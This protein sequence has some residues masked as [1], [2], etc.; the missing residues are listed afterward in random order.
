[1]KK[2]V[3]L[4][5]LLTFGLAAFTQGL[6]NLT[7]SLTGSSVTS[8]AANAAKQLQTLMPLSNSSNAAANSMSQLQLLGL[9]PA[10]IQKFI[11]A[12]ADASTAPQEQSNPLQDVLQTVFDMKIRQDSMQA[13]LD[14]NSNNNKP[15]NDVKPNEIFG[16]DFFGSGKL[17]LFTKSSDSKAPDSYILDVGD[18]ISIAV[19]GNADYNNKFTVN[20][21]GY[22]QIPEFGRIYVKGLTFGAVKAQIGKRLATFINPNNTKYEITLN[23]SRTIDVNIVGEVNTPGTYQIPAINSVYNA[24]NAANGITDIGSVRD[25][26]VRRDGKTIKR[27]DVYDFLFNPLSQ[28]NFFLQKGDFIYVSTQNRLVKIS[29]AVRRPA[30]YELLKGENLKEVIKFAGGFA[31]DAYIKSVQV[32]R[33][34][35]DKSQIIDVDYEQLMNSNSNFEL[36]DGDVVNVSTIPG[37][38]ENSVSI[39]G[40]VRYQGQYELKSGYRVSDLIKIAGGI[41]YETYL[42]RAYI[43][44]KL[45][46]NTYVIQKFS[47]KNILLDENSADNLLLKRS[48][49][50]QLFSKDNFVEKFAVGIDGSV[51]KPT[52]MEYTEGL[53]LNDLLFYAGGLKKEA[54]NSKI[55]IS[56]VMDVDTA[57]DA[58]KKYTPQRVVVR[59]ISIGPNLEVD[60]ASKAFPLAPMDRVFVRKEYGFDDQMTVVIRGEV[61]YPGIYPVL[62][63]DEK[64]LN[65]IER[66]GGLT[67]YAFIK[68]T[69]LTRPDGKLNKTIF[70]LKDAFADSN[71]RANLVLKPGDTIEIPTVN[72]LV[73]IRGAVRYPNLDSLQTISGKFVPGK[74]AR[75][76]IKH[77]AGG[78]KKGAWK[79]STM[80]I[81]PNRKVDYTHSFIGIK[82]YPTVD[83]EGA[84]IT[85]D[86]KQKTPKPPKGPESV[87]NWNIVLPSVIAALTS[88]ASTLTLIFILKK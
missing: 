2:I 87:L 11:K 57:V 4:C 39:T 40:P 82:C 25:I 60:D 45:D 62:K 50:I 43:K 20:S 64:V 74:K 77:Y 86:M 36:K 30:K 61:K 51:L 47:I 16:H 33:T 52:I 35:N 67:P 26:Q 12:K 75:W 63:K 28:E 38:I 73:S 31:P 13:I 59:T 1:M 78:F 69:K 14:R 58:E 53:T 41:K 80:V 55:E 29:G 71:S 49:E 24:I 68:N 70:Q 42:D 54:A 81:Y 85:V 7:G 23:Y 83:I 3:T 10:A 5:F 18:E 48:D 65:L 32:T 84:L 66:A 9:D 8:A 56:R 79:K 17:A 76:Y 88:V 72:Q 21:D 19:W 27:F 37:G 44:R 6:G 34:S 22:I 15:N 46:D